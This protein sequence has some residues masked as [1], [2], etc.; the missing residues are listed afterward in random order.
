MSLVLQLPEGHGLADV[1]QDVS[2]GAVGGGGVFAFATK[3]G[4][5]RFLAIP[6]IRRMLESG[7]RFDLVVGTD[8]IT[9]AEALIC[10]E[11][12]VRS[13]PALHAWAFIHDSPTTFHPK[14]CW[15]AHQDGLCLVV[16]SG[17]LTSSGIGRD[18][19][20]PQRMGNWE[21]LS[22]RSLQGEQ[23][24]GVHAVI[25]RWLA[26]NRAAGHLLH[27]SHPRVLERAVAN[28]RVKYVS[29]HKRERR[30]VRAPEPADAPLQ[31]ADAQTEV[32]IREIPQNRSGQAD[33][34]QRGLAFFGFAGA[35]KKVLIQHVSLDNELDVP[36]ERLIFVNASQNYRIEISEVA[37]LPYVIAPDDGRMVLVAIKLDDS[38][39]RYTIVPVDS[40]HYA[41]LNAILGPIPEGRRFMRTTFLNAADLKARWPG[42]PKNLFPVVAL[43]IEDVD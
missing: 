4:I 29:P 15:F 37:A 31:I 11:E 18:P 5:E 8:A 28:S 19:G 7:R 12:H 23:A 9:N 20:S 34:S 30:E 17:N 32:M 13:F 27:L 14:Y 43:T 38:A 40:P 26:D 6:N 3:R 33:V 10:I 16:G 22:V 36:V 25:T 2:A 42:A 1:I 41:A 21:A 24:E 35:Q 39:Y